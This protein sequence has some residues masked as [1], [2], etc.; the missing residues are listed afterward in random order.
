MEDNHDHDRAGRRDYDPMCLQHRKELDSAIEKIEAISTVSAESSGKYKSMLWFMGI[1]GSI[2]ATLLIVI[3][4][5]LSTVET[6]LTDSKVVLMQ[7]TERIERLRQDV[8][9][10]K[11]RN[12]FIDQTRNISTPSKGEQ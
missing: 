6:L 4:S 10:I 9:E 12:R 2:L 7:H 8:D 11:V 1:A 5:K 3:I